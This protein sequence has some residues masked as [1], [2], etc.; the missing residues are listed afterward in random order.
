MGMGAARRMCNEGW[1]HTGSSGLEVMQLV[2]VAG[3]AG[4]IGES[5][6]RTNLDELSV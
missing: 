3:S 1:D 2:R 4:A 6:L 5:P